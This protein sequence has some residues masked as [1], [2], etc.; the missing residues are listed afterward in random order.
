[1]YIPEDE[2]FLTLL[3]KAM[4]G[5]LSAAER[6]RLDVLSKSD[7][8]R[9]LLRQY[10]EADEPDEQETAELEILYEKSKPNDFIA[11]Q[12]GTPSRVVPIRSKK[13][14]WM[15]G[16]AAA[17]LL[18]VFAGIAY[19]QLQQRNMHGD[20]WQ[21]VSSSKGER[22]YFKLQDG[23]EVWLNSDSQLKI[24]HGFGKTNRRMELVG[25]GYFSVAKNKELPLTVKVNNMDIQ[26]LGTIFNVRAYP[27][28]ER[29]VTSLIEGQVKLKLH[30]KR[31]EK[32][33]L[34]KP[35]D[36][37]EVTKHQVINKHT[38]QQH[39]P[40][41]IEETVAYK[42][43]DM[44][45][46][47]VLD[48]LWVDNKLVFK[49]DSFAEVSKKLER[50]YNKTLIIEN[51]ALLKEECSGVFEEKSCEEVLDLIKKTGINLQYEVKQDTLI[52]H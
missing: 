12:E 34:L 49:G 23:T 37:V 6:S 46:K 19:Q 10:M 3:Q 41:N 9:Q 11:K 14:Y 45:D 38:E 50:W 26:V 16:I 15:L 1:M 44:E 40:S 42:K 30:G 7:A 51:K 39:S 28:D 25:E 31:E 43:I 8:N 52:I 24:Q 17:I 22:K 20:H 48:A 4:A 36:K 27:E 21:L 47:Q 2:E 35:G 32:D 5:N 29:M 13:R 18:C 33:F